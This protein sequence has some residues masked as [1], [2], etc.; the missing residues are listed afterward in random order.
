LKYSYTLDPAIAL[1]GNYAA[2]TLTDEHKEVCTRYL[3][4]AFPHK[5]SIFAYWK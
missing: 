2:N 5:K 1:P 3:F 4:R